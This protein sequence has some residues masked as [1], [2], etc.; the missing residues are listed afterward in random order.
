MYRYGQDI[1]HV[2]A[3]SLTEV[4]PEAQRRKYVG[5]LLCR[6]E[7]VDERVMLGDVARNGI[8]RNGH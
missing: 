1:A 7:D 4:G 6:V 2:E 8:V 3:V 5:E